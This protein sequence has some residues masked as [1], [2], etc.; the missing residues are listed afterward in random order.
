[1]KLVATTPKKIS[2]DILQFCRDVCGKYRPVF[3]PVES[4]I[5]ERKNQCFEN[6]QLRVEES[7]GS[8]VYGWMIMLWPNVLV[9]AIHHGIWETPDGHW[10]DITP[11]HGGET[12]IL[13]LPDP[14]KE[15][16]FLGHRR[17]ANV[18]KALTNDGDVF[19]YIEVCR[20]LFELI[21]KG[22]ENSGLQVTVSASE[23]RALQ[24]CRD[25]LLAKLVPKYI[26]PNNKCPC[27]SGSKYK[28]CHG[29]P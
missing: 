11:K 27:G 22:S 4:E 12:R 25:Q 16:D 5:K 23:Y 17:I 19:A 9:E 15:Y 1:M 29:K 28:H 6:V 10:V 8:Q 2:N 7:G 21:E 18:R 3:V 20:S 13:F 24:L 26:R 14:Q